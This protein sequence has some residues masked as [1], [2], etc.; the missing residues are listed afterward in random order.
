MKELTKEFKVNDYITLKLENGKTNIYFNNTLFRHCKYLLLNI[1]TNDLEH[2]ENIDSIDEIAEKLDNGLE[3]SNLTEIRIPPEQEFEGHCSNLQAWSEY[4]YDTRLLHRN[5]A[6]SLLKKLTDAGDAQAKR[7]F[8][9]E[10]ARRFASGFKPVQDYLIN[11][12]YIWY[13]NSEELTYLAGTNLNLNVWKSYGL[14]FIKIGAYKEAKK[15]FELFIKADTVDLSNFTLGEKIDNR[16][17]F[18]FLYFCSY[19]SS[20]E[21]ITENCNSK[22]FS[23]NTI[24]KSEI[25]SISRLNFYHTEFNV[26]L[27]YFIYLL[28]KLKLEKELITLAAINFPKS[29]KYPKILE[30]VAKLF[31]Y[32]SANEI[33]KKILKEK[34]FFID[35]VNRLIMAVNFRL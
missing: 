7:V 16:A 18:S 27:R 11:N 19:L 34:K 25:D 1:P 30:E 8:K 22:A 9:E 6:F 35:Y 28:V 24:E 4:G 2:F 23:L 3:H 14:D 17:L 21:K 20:P 29:I 31:S 26:V 5:L 13:L 33:S 10:I 15:I 32:K 12:G